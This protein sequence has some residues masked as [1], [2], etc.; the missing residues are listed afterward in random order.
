VPGEPAITVNGLTCEFGGIRALNGITFSIGHAVLHG[1]VGPNGSGKT[2]LLRAIAGV[3]P[4]STGQVLVEGRPPHQTPAPILARRMA[5]LPQHPVAPLG[6]TVR[7]AVSWGRIPHLGRLAAAGP[8]DLRAIDRALD[9][10]GIQDLAGRSVQTLSGGERQRALIARALAQEPRILLLDEPTVHLDVAHQIEVMQV[11]RRLA[12]GGLT[13]VVALHHLELAAVYCDRLTLLA[14][15]RLLA[16]GVPAE[17]LTEN[18]V[19]EAY[20]DAAVGRGS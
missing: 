10:T 18:L 4:P 3:V 19:R 7:E 15:G 1:L 20:G 5:V 13:I 14:R 6:V 17:V 9:A 11:L 8:D 2:T 12:D 16:S